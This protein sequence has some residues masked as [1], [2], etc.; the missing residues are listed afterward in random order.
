MTSEGKR[1]RDDGVQETKERVRFFSKSFQKM[2]NKPG[3]QNYRR[4]YLNMLHLISLFSTSFTISKT[5]KC[6]M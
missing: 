4:N 5:F 3:K 2:F 6:F 1:F